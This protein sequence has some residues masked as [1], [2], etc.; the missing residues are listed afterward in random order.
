MAPPSMASSSCLSSCKPST[1][2]A[3]AESTLWCAHL[4]PLTAHFSRCQG[5]CLREV[6]VGL[7]ACHGDQLPFNSSWSD[8]PSSVKTASSAQQEELKEPRMCRCFARGRSLQTACVSSTIKA[9]VARKGWASPSQLTRKHLH[10]PKSHVEKPSQGPVC[11]W[12]GLWG[13]LEVLDLH[14]GL[15]LSQ[16]ARQ[17]PQEPEELPRAHGGAGLLQPGPG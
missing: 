14:A 8:W 16:R 7:W 15:Q 1:A 13:L 11:C 3:W 5:C 9:W 6:F 17:Q 10:T 2:W 12:G 4:P